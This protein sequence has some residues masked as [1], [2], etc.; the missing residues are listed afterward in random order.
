MLYSSL[1]YSYINRIFTQ[2]GIKKKIEKIIL[3]EF[4]FY[5][6]LLVNN[7]EHNIYEYFFTLHN[8]MLHYYLLVRTN[9]LW[10]YSVNTIGTLYRLHLHISNTKVGLLSV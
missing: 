8:L 3:N 5:M 10:Y 1:F 2:L 7:T 6:G 4:Q 9:E